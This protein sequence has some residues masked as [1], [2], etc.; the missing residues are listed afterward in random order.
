MNI[1]EIKIRL[2]EHISRS[3]TAKVI[4]LLDNLIVRENDIY[5]TFISIKANHYRLKREII[6]GLISENEKNVQAAKTNNS[7]I[8]LVDMIEQQDIDEYK[9]VNIALPVLVIT[10]TDEK[11]KALG[12]QFRKMGFENYI[13]TTD[14]A[15]EK[16]KDVTI[17]VFDNRHLAACPSKQVFNTL[18]SEQQDAINKVTQFMDSVVENSTAYI[19]HYGEFLFWVNENRERTQA[20]NSQFTLFARIKEMKDFIDMVKI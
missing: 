3:E 5:N 6:Q 17:V 12:T 20:A 8:S 4:E 14:L 19:I 1:K 11:A 2:K 16:L 9:I 13:I 7:F 15:I 10:Q 18:T